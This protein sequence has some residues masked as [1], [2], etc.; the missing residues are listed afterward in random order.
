MLCWFSM[1]PDLHE[2]HCRALSRPSYECIMCGTICG[3]NNAAA[4][5]LGHVEIE[6]DFRENVLP[7]GTFCFTSAC[8]VCA[9]G[10]V[11]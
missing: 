8:L 11:S 5:V 3:I 7:S 10:R 6:Q 1:M 2:M 9:A 4:A